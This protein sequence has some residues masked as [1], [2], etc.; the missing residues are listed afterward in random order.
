MDYK[1]IDLDSLKKVQSTEEENTD[2]M[3]KAPAESKRTKSLFEWLES[4]VVS[5][6]IIVVLFS[7]F[8]GKVK[9]DGPSMLETLK[10]G[11]QLIVTNFCYTPKRG[12]I[13]I[14]SRNPKNLPD[15]VSQ[16][17]TSSQPIVKRVIAIE[18]D[19]IE[20]KDKKVYLNGKELDEPYIKDYEVGPHT[21]GHYLDG[22]GPQTVPEGCI[23]VMGDN[24]NDSHDSRMND[25][26]MIDS[27]YVLGKVLFR[28][29]PFDQ[30]KSFM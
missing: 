3:A 11:D 24:R 17:K 21:D 4:F 8:F 5:L 26:Y 2:Y 30:V 22:K 16:K 13:V 10:S 29:F 25:I 12:D 14:V 6:I 18:G 9:V 27:R 1:N 20:I 7:V 28:I 23:F 15:S 19:T